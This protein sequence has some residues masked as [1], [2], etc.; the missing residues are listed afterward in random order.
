MAESYVYEN[1]DTG[2]R[3]AWNGKD[4]IPI[5]KGGGAQSEE[6]EAQAFTQTRQ[7]AAI[8]EPAFQKLAG[9]TIPM[10]AAGASMLP[11]VGPIAAGVL[12]GA[13]TALNQKAGFEP[14]DSSQV[15]LSAAM[16]LAAKGAVSGIK[17]LSKAAGKFFAPG[18]TRTAGVEAAMESAG[19]VPNTINRAFTT[20]ASKAAYAEVARQ[21]PVATPPIVNA[22]DMALDKITHMANPS[23]PAQKHLENL[24]AKYK[25]GPQASYANVVEEMQDLRVK[26]QGAL[27]RGDNITSTKLYEARATILDELD[28]ISPAIK[29]ANRLYRREQ[30]VEQISRVLS[31]PRPDVKLGE[32][33]IRD[34]LVRGIVS[35]QDA[36]MFDKIAKQLSTMGTQAS[37][38]SGVGARA[39]NFIAAPLAAAMA[40][41]TGQYL[42]RQTFK[43][44]KVTPQGIAMIG[45]FMRAYEA[46]GAEL[47]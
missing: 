24:L 12:S 31:N 35:K 13:G 19:A 3:V 39:L 21:G 17:G 33:L 32:L 27:T 46:S 20:P 5:P 43:Q 10:I 45:Q 7:Q 4:W 29:N 44:G 37:P 47:E 38:Y 6:A 9:A 15:A 18:A 42:L 14:E 30:A 26:A 23:K 41:K 11:G 25:S 2:E 1:P 40:S 28:K 36:Q 34:P 16:P 8:R 22:I